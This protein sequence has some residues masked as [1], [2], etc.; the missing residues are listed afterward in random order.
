M[1]KE[2]PIQVLEL[3]TGFSVRGLILS[4]KLDI[5]LETDLPNVVKIKREIIR[6]IVAN[7]HLFISALNPLDYDELKS[8]GD[9]FFKKSKDKRVV[10]VQE[11]LITYFSSDEQEQVRRNISRFLQEYCPRWGWITT[12]FSY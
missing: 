5:Y 7:K 9:R 10:I 2:K 3:S 8:I 1:K 6:K 12:D 4:S 11:D